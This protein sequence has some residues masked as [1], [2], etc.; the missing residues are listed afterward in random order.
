MA[1]H[2]ANREGSFN[3][4]PMHYGVAYESVH[5]LARGHVIERA[6]NKYCSTIFNHKL[7]KASNLTQNVANDFMSQLAQS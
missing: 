7:N 2:A 6:S 5:S 4:I 3:R 1:C